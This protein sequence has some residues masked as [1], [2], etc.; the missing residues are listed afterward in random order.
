MS[1]NPVAEFFNRKA[2]AYAHGPPAGM[3]TLNRRIAAELESSITGD[4]LSVGGIWSQCSRAFLDKKSVAVTVLD[5]SSEML[6]QLPHEGLSKVVGDARDL[7]FAQSSY[8]HVVFPLVLHHITDQSFSASR[9]NVCT[10]LAEAWRILRPGG[11]LWVSD[12]LVSRPIYGA[13]RLL[14]PVTT[15]LLALRR[16]P[17]VIMHSEQFY[18][19]SLRSA[20]FRSIDVERVK[21]PDAKPGDWIRP[22]IGLGL[23]IPRWTYPLRSVLIRAQKPML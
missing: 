17:L 7:P 2:A 9:R 23:R 20:G 11:W 18:R 19:S 10:A 4:I 5:A 12:F 3:A 21:S 8:D 15:R 16:I 14:S 6:A 22:V 1:A 13:E